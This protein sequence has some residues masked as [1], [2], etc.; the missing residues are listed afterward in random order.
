[1]SN[2]IIALLNAEN[3]Y[4]NDLLAPVKDLRAELFEEMKGQIK[5]NDDS[6]PAKDGP[7]EY[8]SRYETGKEYA[9]FCRRKLKQM[10]K[11]FCWTLTLLLKGNPI[12]K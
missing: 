8:F 9:I 12:F 11:K 10:K 2:E 4:A 1:M 6:V 7:F 3:D 5:E